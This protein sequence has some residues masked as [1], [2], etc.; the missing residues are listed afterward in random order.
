MYD[1]PWAR[2]EDEEPNL[3]AQQRPRFTEP[4]RPEGR[5]LAPTNVGLGG[6]GSS[7]SASGTSDMDR[8]LRN[9]AHAIASLTNEERRVAKMPSRQQHNEQARPPWALVEDAGPAGRNAENSRK[10]RIA[11]LAEKHEK[12][13]TKAG[14]SG[15]VTEHGAARDQ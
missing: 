1:P 8:D 11:D 9:R 14:G 7:S 15:N 3:D 12:R 10:K 6:R 13:G 4:F 2:W 5:I